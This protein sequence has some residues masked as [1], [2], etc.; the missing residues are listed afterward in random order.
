MAQYIE[1]SQYNGTPITDTFDVFDG[2]MPSEDGLKIA[3]GAGNFEAQGISVDLKAARK[4][5][6]ASG[7][8]EITGT[9]VSL[10]LKQPKKLLINPA[11]LTVVGNDIDLRY[12]L[13]SADSKPLN[14]YY[15]QN[16][17]R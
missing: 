17:M 8:L 16:I 2:W 11:V 1:L 5:A 3:I 10:N 7:L 13:L 14:A 12:W 6:A 4:V 9:D 15:F